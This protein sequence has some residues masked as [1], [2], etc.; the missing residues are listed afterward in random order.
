MYR[1]EG[2]DVESSCS[3]TMIRLPCKLHTPHVTRIHTTDITSV[4][5][6]FAIALNEEHYSTCAMVGVNQS[7]PDGLPGCK[8]DLGWGVQRDRPLGC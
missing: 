3:P 2:P 1:G 6:S 8:L 7:D 4:Q 5:D